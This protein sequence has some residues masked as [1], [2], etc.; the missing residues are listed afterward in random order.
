[1]VSVRNGNWTEFLRIELSRL[2]IAVRSQVGARQGSLCSVELCVPPLTTRQLQ[3]ASKLLVDMHY[4]HYINHRSTVYEVHVSTAIVGPKPVSQAL[5]I[6]KAIKEHYIFVTFIMN[7][8]PSP[9]PP[10]RSNKTRLPS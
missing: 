7:N 9:K 5:G 3:T 4:C 6:T 8:S 1:M 10:C 2:Y